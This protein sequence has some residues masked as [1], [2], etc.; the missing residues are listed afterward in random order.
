NRI[1]AVVSSCGFTTLPRYKG[2]DLTDW[3][4]PR[5]MPRLRTV[6]KDD[7]A[8]IPFDF[9]EVL[10][11]LA[12]RAVFVSAPLHDTVMDVEGVKSAVA[13]ASAVYELRRVGKA[14]QAVYPDS[15]RDFT[16]AARAEAY[17]WLD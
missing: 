1:A 13:S 17:K 8:K 9:A 11:T 5:L 10:G 3:A 12:P 4:N 15:G 2:G 16:A 7:P 6:Y 14:L